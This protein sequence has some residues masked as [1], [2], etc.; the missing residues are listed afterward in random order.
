MAICG[1]RQYVIIGK[2]QTCSSLFD[3]CVRL[4]W[5]NL[6]ALS[7]V[8]CI[9]DPI[10][11]TGP[12]PFCTSIS[13]WASIMYELKILIHI[14]KWIELHVRLSKISSTS[15]SIGAIWYSLQPILN[16][17]THHYLAVKRAIISHINFKFMF[18]CTLYTLYIHISVVN[19]P[20]PNILK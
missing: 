6:G 13:L 14:C 15:K 5:Y 1:T 20:H 16:R 17:C 4:K 2:R 12:V 7:S 11:L 8:P 9:F 10:S 3:L 19:K 18:V